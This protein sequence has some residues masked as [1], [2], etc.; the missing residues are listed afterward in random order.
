MNTTLNAP[1]PFNVIVVEAGGT[2]VS[3][4]QTFDAA[5]AMSEFIATRKTAFG[6]TYGVG[7]YAALVDPAL[8]IDA[9]FL[10]E[11]N[12]VYR[13]QFGKDDGLRLHEQLSLAGNDATVPRIPHLVVMQEVRQAVRNTYL[14]SLVHSRPVPGV[15]GF[16]AGYGNLLGHYENRL[17][18]SSAMAQGISEHEAREQYL[19][20][21]ANKV[22]SFDV[23]EAANW[24]RSKAGEPPF[25]LGS[26]SEPIG[27]LAREAADGV[28][29]QIDAEQRLILW[30]PTDISELLHCM[31]GK[32]LTQ[33]LK[34]L[35]NMQP[36][37]LGNDFWKCRGIPNLMNLSEAKID[38]AMSLAEELLD[39]IPAPRSLDTLEQ[40]VARICHDFLRQQHVAA[41]GEIVAVETE[42]INRISKIAP[43][44]FD[45]RRFGLPTDDMVYLLCKDVELCQGEIWPNHRSVLALA[46]RHDAVSP[47]FDPRI[48]E[49]MP[50]SPNQMLLVGY[51]DG[52]DG[53]L[54]DRLLYSDITSGREYL[55]PNNLANTNTADLLR[56][57]LG[58]LKAVSE[59]RV[60]QQQKAKQTGKP[61]GA[62]TLKELSQAEQEWAEILRSDFEVVQKTGLGLS[63]RD[64][65]VAKAVHA[66]RIAKSVPKRAK[67]SNRLDELSS[68][69]FGANM[70]LNWDG[71]ATVH[72]EEEGRRSPRYV[73]KVNDDRL[74][75]NPVSASEAH[76]L[77]TRIN[78]ISVY[79]DAISPLQQFQP[80]PQP[81]HGFERDQL[82]SPA[83]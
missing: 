18:R 70:P 63:E 15:E 57:R 74:S 82:A 10:F 52:Q 1:E 35:Q 39:N 59:E 75:S 53:L 38:A 25:E 44:T 17:L 79:A 61:L 58:M 31:G 20:E 28:I 13:Q 9:S 46:A 56:L 72:L 45:R 24:L 62:A 78:L 8:R 36:V 50:F 29:A 43:L 34:V 48:C 7:S 49:V 16:E 81:A 67:A 41:S 40:R 37:T 51:D 19:A 12:G 80:R 69:A 23:E 26:Y 14:T 66:M 76:I 71:L 73:V 30:L 21:F 54:V 5:E 77:S 65:Q 33:A 22:I 68:A 2:T 32:E 47:E 60:A 4:F 27:A 3:A 11:G 6:P 42:F 64:I 55:V 83:P